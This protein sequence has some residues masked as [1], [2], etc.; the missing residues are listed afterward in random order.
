VKS[1]DRLLW[2]IKQAASP[3][4]VVAYDHSHFEL[5]GVSMDESWRLLAPYSRFVHVKEAVREAG[6]VKFLLPG[7]AKTDYVKY[8]NLLQGAGYAGPVV[9]EVS[10]QLFS[11][12]TYDPIQAAEKSYAALA[13]PLAASTAYFGAGSRA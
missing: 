4:I 7:E 11:K 1:P 3:A 5:A 6:A 10:S 2:I 9:V 8:F 13:G 12:N